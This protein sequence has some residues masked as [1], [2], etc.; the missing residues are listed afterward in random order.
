M[1]DLA[2]SAV[3]HFQPSDQLELAKIT[4][5][6]AVVRWRKA[7]DIPPGLDS[8]YYYIVWL[9]AAGEVERNVA[10]VPHTAD[11]DWFEATVKPLVFNRR[12]S[13]S[14]KAY[15]QHKEERQGGA[16]M[17]VTSFKTSCIGTICIL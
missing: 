9:E 6:T 1:N 8:Q 5:S 10:R 15:R 4:S 11:T 3:P 14:V 7:T 13:V 17:D 2:S 12:Y 16:R